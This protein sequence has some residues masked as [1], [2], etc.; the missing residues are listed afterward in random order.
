TKFIAT[1]SLLIYIPLIV[2]VSGIRTNLKR[3]IMYCITFIVIAFVVSFPWFLY[4]FV[5]TGNPVYPIFS[6]YPLDKNPL[7]LVSLINFI[8]E[9]WNILT[10][11]QDPINPIYIIFFPLIILYLKELKK[12]EKIFALYSVLG[13]IVWYIT[14][15]TGGGRFILPYLPIVSIL[16]IMVLSKMSLRLKKYSIVL[17]ILISLI[18]IGYR[19]FANRR[20]IPV[21]VGRQTKANFLSKNLNFKFGDFY[22]TDGYFART[23]KPTDQVLIFGIHNLYYVNF[24]FIHESYLDKNDW[25]N[26]ILVGDEKMPQKYSNWKLIYQNSITGIKLFAH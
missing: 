23:L 4:S 8:S 18:S 7:H 24:P 1:A 9:G 10:R 12:Y 5:H 25:F 14:P 2:S 15:R 17:I 20:Y 21:I 13:F 11:S 26:Y 19:A 3:T 22:D 6:G 16:V